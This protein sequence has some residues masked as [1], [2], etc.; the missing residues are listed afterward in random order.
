[1]TVPGGSPLNYPPGSQPPLRRIAQNRAPRP[2]DSKNFRE[3]DEWLDKLTAQ[4]WK[5]M[6]ITGNVATWNRIGGP[7]TSSEEFIPDS[8]TSPVVPNGSNQIT[9]TGGA[10][11][12]VIGGT[13]TLTIERSGDGFPITPYVVGPSG[14]AGYQTIQ[15]ALDAANTSGGGMVFVQAGTYTEDLTFYTNIQM[16]G[17]S[18][19]G[20]FITGV[21]TPPDS[22]TLNLFRLTFNSA[23]HILSSTA[24]GTATIIMEDITVN[25]TNGYT[26]NLPNWT[27]S[28]QAFD[29]GPAGTNDGFW[30]N[31]GGGNLFVFAAGV[32]NGTGNSLV[33]SGTL[34]F[35]GAVDVGC[36]LTLGNG[37]SFKSVGSSY[38]HTITLTGNAT[39]TFN[40]DILSTG[41]TAAID[42]TSM[43]QVDIN[44]SAIDS[45]NNPSITGTG[46]IKITGG[47]FLNNT[48]TAGTLTLTGGR[49]KTG[50]LEIV[51]AF[52]LPT[53]DGTNGQFMTTDGAGT[54]S[55]TSSGSLGSL[56]IQTFTASGTYTPT[57]GM[58]EAIIEIVGAGG[59]GSGAPAGEAGGGGGAGG[60]SRRKV[61][62]ADVGVSQ[63]VT[64]GSGGTGGV[65]NAAGTAGG[66]TS[67]GAL[68]SATG[69][70]GGSPG[71]A[72]GAGGV[73]SLGDLN[74]NGSR[75]G[76][77]VWRA[78][79][80]NTMSLGGEG[81][82]TFFGQ[83]A[84][85]PA[86]ADAGNPNTS[87][88]GFT[89]LVKGCGGSGG[90]A[91]G[92]STATGGAGSDGLVVI[93]E[94][95]S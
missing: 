86:L 81:G 78:G 45:T 66:T 95:I 20:T 56:N 85:A 58:E 87:A 65:G 12:E 5:L 33:A 44:N 26:F 14:Q 57:A 28:V 83:G 70:G 88:N 34:E 29:I 37:T 21:H 17:D 89:A 40:S 19:Q 68:I 63:V 76:P 55:W 3:G 46:P 16:F 82:G 54:A 64:I 15:A 25:V 24:A 9:I 13:N 61:T 43:G 35:A 73:G 52:T 4:W 92:T 69:G 84:G 6:D 18:E 91:L 67:V 80:S 38:E 60:Y 53:T 72:A 77:G 51:N 23:T 75:G 32:G 79:G 59:G 94:Y 93:T 8:G 62:A 47:E 1:M 27:G 50:S 11:L 22:G 49:S 90:C 31:T 42:H 2:N 74:L 48:A 41:A 7:S 36:P 30:N 10:G 71:H 39:A